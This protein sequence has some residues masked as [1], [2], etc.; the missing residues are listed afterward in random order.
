MIDA[1]DG[2]HNQRCTA[3]HCSLQSLICCS[4]GRPQWHSQP[5]RRIIGEHWCLN[6][7]ESNE[8]PLH[9]TIRVRLGISSALS[10]AS[11]AVMLRSDLWWNAL[12]LAL[13]LV[14]VKQTL[15]GRAKRKRRKS[16][17]L[18]ALSYIC[19][20]RYNWLT[21]QQHNRFHCSPRLRLIPLLCPF[22]AGTASVLFKAIHTK[23]WKRTKEIQTERQWHPNQ[24]NRFRHGSEPLSQCYPLLLGSVVSKYEQ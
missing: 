10:M 13:T 4:H 18:S 23:H 20:W 8:M 2:E 9:K 5:S 21:A 19:I 12:T 1:I 17:I 14:S 6:E 11:M 24:C 22:I 15:F 3:S 16:I 7:K